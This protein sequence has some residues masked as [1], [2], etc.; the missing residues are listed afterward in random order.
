MHEDLTPQKGTDRKLSGATASSSNKRK[1]E[2]IAEIRDFI[3]RSLEDDK[4]EGLVV[5]DLVGRTSLTDYMIFA[6]GLSMRQV[7]AMAEHL[8][9][10]L[11]DKGKRVRLEGMESGEWVLIDAGDIIVHLFCPEA[12]ER[13]Q[14][15][16]IWSPEAMGDG[17]GDGGGD[18]DWGSD[19]ENG[20]TG[21]K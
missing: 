1:K 10:K 11:A 18:G 4:A 16:E 5:Y 8:R 3:V 13:Y 15:E 9:D 7:S 2:N 17:G 19:G 20:D 12:R 6:S 21:G 14:L